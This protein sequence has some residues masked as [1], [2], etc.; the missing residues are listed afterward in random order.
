MG[1]SAPSADDRLPWL[2]APRSAKV[3]P[4]AR[5][6][7][8]PLLVLLGLFLA[9]A[10]AMMAFLAGR[11]SAP[12]TAPP[13]VTTRIAPPVVPVP[14]PVPVPMP[15]PT[16]QMAPP[17]SVMATPAPVVVADARVAPA[18]PRATRPERKRKATIRRR[19]ARTATP[20]RARV[21]VHRTAPHARAVPKAYAAPRRRANW[22][23]RP[24]AGPRGR[25]VQLG[26]YTTK[27]Q[28]DAAWW[29]VARAYPYLATLPRVVT[30][31]G[32]SRGRPRYYRIR[33]AAGSNR[34]ARALCRQLHRV[35][36]GCIIA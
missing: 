1:G 25:V 20:R 32:P 4:A 30:V 5:R 16:P 9:S 24:F 14:V 18:K 36:R 22:P 3:P 2:D 21:A 10:V 6:A 31:I 12:V 26:A 7:R 34:E 8:T 27:P 23:A 35:G 33:L 29:R 15:I 19:S 17:A 13:E 28:A 11:G